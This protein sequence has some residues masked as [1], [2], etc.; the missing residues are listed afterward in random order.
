MQS[1]GV[2]IKAEGL[3]AVPHQH[4]GKICF[5]LHAAYYLAYSIWVGK[6]N[7]HC[8]TTYLYH[9]GRLSRDGSE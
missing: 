8:D 5:N 3:L 7:C 2:L 4:T 9:Q 6:I 1:R